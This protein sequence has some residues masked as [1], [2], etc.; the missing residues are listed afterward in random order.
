MTLRRAALIVLI[1]L[2][3]VPS[4]LAGALWFALQ[5]DLARHR[6]EAAVERATGHALRIAGAVHITPSLVPTL[7]VD[8]VALLNPPGF[9]RPAL[10]HARRVEARVAL[11]PLLRGRVEVRNVRVFGLDAKLEVNAAGQRNWQRPPAP[12]PAAA[13]PPSERRRFTL[14]LRRVEL[15][16]AA[17]VWS[18]PGHA[19]QVNLPDLTADL[20]QT[21]APLAVAATV[22]S[23]AA[24]T[25]RLQ[26]TLADPETP[27][28][29][30]AL[31][32][33]QVPDLAALLP[34]APPLHDVTLTA[35]LAD[36]DGLEHGI[37]IR[38]LTA[39]FPQGDIAGDLTASW[40]PRPVLR[41]NLRSKRLDAD[42]LLATLRER[43]PAPVP[44][45]APPS[46]PSAPAPARK[47][48]IPDTPVPV[49]GLRAADAELTYGADA[50]RLG[51]TEFHAVQV[52]IHLANGALRL[53]PVTATS[54][55]GPLQARAALDA[56]AAPPRL[57]LALVTPSLDLGVLM[58][59]AAG[60]VSINAD[61]NGQGAT[62][63]AIAAALGGDA[64]LTAVDG[65]LDLG[66]LGALSEV[67]RRAGVPAALS[68][69]ASLRCLALRAAASSGT[70]TL[71]PLV[72]DAGR[73]ALNGTGQVNLGDESLDLHLRAT[74]RAGPANAAIPVHV[75]G[76]LAEPKVEAEKIG[77]RF[78]L[79]VAGAPTADACGPALAAARGGRPG[80]EPAAPP[81]GGPNQP[82]SAKPA[83]LLRSLLR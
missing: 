56:G 66:K 2:L 41:G 30:D 67:L 64:D 58:P 74:V 42:A 80:P 75:T 17:L 73:L 69:E 6:A 49:A 31:L 37:A 71:D 44:A 82:R 23:G 26:A 33:V 51:R 54:P 65:Q 21:G 25:A 53:D 83:D 12:P 29:L 62:W 22:I 46:P 19:F 16:N 32:S 47:R 18:S 3:A 4:T 40:Q 76:T 72:L 10:A 11:L 48:L 50:L 63:R 57:S 70:A 28:G 61:L 36:P 5:T 45:A 24:A 35:H 9:S 68:G 81:S 55:A 52:G 59:G 1:V 78:G 77:G 15:A 60:A 7:A 38:D 79:R 27:R 20:G 8:D 14:A 34:G 39:S 13:P 43:S